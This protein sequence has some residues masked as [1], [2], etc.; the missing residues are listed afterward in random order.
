MGR[1]TQIL[2]PASLVLFG[3]LCL[4]IAVTG[5]TVYYPKSSPPIPMPP[6]LGRFVFGFMGAFALFLAIWGLVHQR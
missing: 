4:W 1:M 3:L 2:V 6:R 5:K